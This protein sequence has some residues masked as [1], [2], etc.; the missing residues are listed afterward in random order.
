MG[1]KLKY[2]SKAK[3]ETSP[4]GYLPVPSKLCD[5]MTLSWAV[6]E[7]SGA[8]AAKSQGGLAG[9]A[10]WYTSGSDAQD[11]KFLEQAGVF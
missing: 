2:S 1:L 9:K 8:W 3:W 6:T 5:P 7:L 11:H 10:Y 4:Q